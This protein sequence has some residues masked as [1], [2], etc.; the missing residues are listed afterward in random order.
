M[1]PTQ[2]IPERLKE[3]L[4]DGLVELLAGSAERLGGEQIAGNIRKFSSRGDL[5]QSIDRALEAGVRR[6]IKEYMGQ[7]EDL[8]EAVRADDLFWQSEMV[9]DALVKLVSRPSA[10]LGEERETVLRH[11]ETLWPT[12]VNRERVDKAITFLLRCIAEELWSLPGAREIREAY[13]IQFQELS[14]EAQREGVALA[15]QQLQATT[16]MNADLRQ[17][18]LQLIGLVEQKV[19]AAPAPVAMLASPR[20][21]HNLPQ[22][23]YTQFVGRD[24]ELVWLRQRLSPADRAWQIGITGIGGVGKSALALAIGHENRERY[25]ELSPEERFEAIVWVSAKEE[26]LTAFGRERANV[27][28]QVLHTLEDVYTAIARVLERED[29][30]RAQP[31]EQNAL[32]EKALKRQRTLLIMDNLESVKD[33]RIKAFLRNLPPPTKAII[34]SRESLDVADVKP[35]TGLPWDKAERLIEEDCRVRE[36][37][38]TLQQ[39]KHIFELTSGLPLPIKLGIARMAGGESFASVDRWLGNSTGELS[40]YC[41]EGQLDL[42]RQRNPNAWTMLLVCALFDR[43]AGASREALGKITDLS[44]VDRDAALAQLQRLLLV[45]RREDDRFW[46]LPIVQRRASAEIGTHSE[47]AD[48]VRR[49]IQWSL[50]FVRLYDLETH[51]DYETALVVGREFANLR[52]ALVWCRDNHRHEELFALCAALSLYALRSD[53]YSHLEVILE[54]WLATAT[55]AGCRIDEGR[56]CAWLG[57]LYQIWGQQTEAVEYLDRAEAILGDYPNEPEL[58]HS[59][60]V[61]ADILTER[62]TLDQ[63][64]AMAQRILETAIRVA[65]L[66]YQVVAAYRLALVA[67]KRGNSADV[68]RWLDQAEQWASELNSPRRLDNIRYRR[69]VNLSF[70]GDF[71]AAEGILDNL[72][73]ENVVKGQ[74]RYVALNKYRLAHIYFHTGR[75]R[76][77]RQSAKEARDM[78]ED[79]GAGRY[80]TRVEALLHRLPEEEPAGTAG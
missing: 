69:A 45:N 2:L 29:I 38:L 48:L 44:Y 60:S 30:T 59:W 77:A 50:D 10:W 16:Q 1:D 63:A 28:E 65:D 19:L 55:E 21:Y 43:A 6:F 64:E 26:V 36:V 52:L 13:S 71:A 11:F 76:L 22:P 3:K 34:T 4:A 37:S 70:Q 53:L 40:E 67:R 20:P 8:V 58:M 39:Q 7:D 33:D 74:R 25:S 42:A 79:L 31:E 23:T 54:T 62:S 46:I 9:Q 61:R 56:A 72:L 18:L 14:A 66:D 12:R 57:E 5:L 17:A 49:W 68:A 75:L 78:F 24:D 73:R 15:R 51:G 41:I 32:V 27:P 47:T 80:L 35:L